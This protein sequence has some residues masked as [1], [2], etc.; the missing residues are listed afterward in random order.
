ML[1]NIE[2]MNRGDWEG[3]AADF[4]QDAHNF[5]QPVGR[6]RIRLVLEDVLRT[7]PDW[8]MDVLDV[9]AD[10]TRVVVRCQVSGTHRGAGR[11]PVNGGKLVGVPPTGRRF[12]VQHIQWFEVHNGE[13]VDHYGARDD[14]GMMVQLGLYPEAVATVPP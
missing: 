8:T 5:G 4:A 1:G 6:E 13:I 2:K 10:A 14:L 3:A 9:T 7:F 12:S 11:L